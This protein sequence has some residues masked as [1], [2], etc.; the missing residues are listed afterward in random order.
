MSET[1]NFTATSG[2]ATFHSQNAFVKLTEVRWPQLPPRHQF[3][4][5]QVRQ[6]GGPSPGAQIELYDVTVLHRDSPWFDLQLETR[7]TL[8]TSTDLIHWQDFYT[9]TA[10]SRAMDA[11]QALLM[12]R[13]FYRLKWTP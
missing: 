9:F 12:D 7:Y 10:Y 8:Q 2:G 1:F 13:I 4:N 5:V 3:D 6:N 11:G